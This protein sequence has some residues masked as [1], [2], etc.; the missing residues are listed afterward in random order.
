LE[1]KLLVNATL[2]YT[3]VTDVQVPTLVLPDAV[4]VTRNTG[5]LTS[6]G[7]EVELRTLLT[8]GLELSYDLGFTDASYESLLIAQDGNEV[9][10]KEN[11]QIYTPEVTSMFALQYNSNLGFGSN[12]NFSARAEWK[13]LGEQYFDLANNLRQEPYNLYNGNLGLSYKNVELMIWGRNIFDTR[14][15]SYGYNFG[16]VHLGNPAT[17][18]VTIF[19]EM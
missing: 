18:G 13:Y 19:L 4:I 15:I 10:L 12:W 2:F 8:R 6:K 9:N 11:K 1:N 3:E 5:S 7:F 16:A 14:Y 17:M